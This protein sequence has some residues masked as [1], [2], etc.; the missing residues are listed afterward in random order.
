MHVGYLLTRAASHHPD[1][2]AWMLEDRRVSFGQAEKR[3]NAL[4]NSLI[5][6]GGQPGDRVGMLVPNRLEGLE[7]L[8]APMK[9]RMAV[10][11]LNVRLHPKEHEFILND[12]GCFAL[13][14]D[15]SF[16]EHVAGMRPS[17]ETV[18]QFIRIGQ[19]AEGDSSY[20]DLMG[21]GQQE[22]PALSRSP[23]DLAW[24]FYTSG[25]TGRPKGGM[26]SHRNLMTMVS[27][28]LVDVN[29]ATVDDVLLHAAPI[30]HGSGMSIFHHI[31]R[32]AASAFPSVKSFEPP[33]IF[34]AIEKYRATTLFLA[35][36]MINILVASPDKSNYDLSSL[37]TVIYGG[38]PMYSEHLIEAMRCFGNIFVQVYG[39]GESP[40]T[41]TTLPK[42]EHLVGDDPDRKRRL[43]SAGRETANVRIRVVDEQG[44]Q[45]PPGQPGE[46][47]VRSDLVMKGYWNRPETNEEVLRDGWFHTGD[48]G[49]L[50]SEGYLFITDRMKDM[51]ISGGANIYPREV[52]E[53]ISQHPAV[54]EVAVIG[55]PDEKWGEAVSA[56]VIK[57]DGAEVSAGEI[58][59]YC[60]DH[61]ASYKKPQSV[62]FLISLP[63]NAY[64]KV[65]KRELRE[66]YWTGQERKV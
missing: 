63:K 9:A 56:L 64:G 62:E 34:A 37:H 40:M 6:L 18:K 15:S 36:T 14:Y 66:P 35:P 54:A 49:Y 57:K 26:L 25:T 65:L 50:D 48:V 41:I 38:S 31:A 43:G 39:L 32:G 59:E 16:T 23:E 55:V 13:I 7:T 29:P 4:A 11:P 17:L 61:L 24:V 10:V 52:E 27:N 8:L 47:V 45:L 51:I 53:V 58:I 46:I 1:R 28:F 22:E 42:E 2:P 3:V 19:G 21:S 33:C 12:S 20:E 60:K 30:T 44:N 5:A